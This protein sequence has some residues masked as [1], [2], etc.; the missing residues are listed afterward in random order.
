[1]IPNGIKKEHLL[2]AIMEIDRTG[3]PPKRRSTGY[4]LIYRNRKYPPK[5]V[6][7]LAGRIAGLPPFG[8]F[9]GNET[10][11]FLKDF[12]FI[13]IEKQDLPRR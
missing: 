2:E 5:Y 3:V 6:I 13:I 7:Y 12:G 4:D 1:M 11:S 8:F 9:G 10:N